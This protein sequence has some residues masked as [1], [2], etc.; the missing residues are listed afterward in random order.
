M[1]AHVTAD[2]RFERAS[3]ARASW[4]KPARR[5]AEIS[6]GRAPRA[7]RGAGCGPRQASGAG[8]SPAIDARSALA[9]DLEATGSV[10]AAS[11]GDDGIVDLGFHYH[12]EPPAI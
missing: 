8:A 4:S 2:R 10:A 3:E 6:S 5:M 9:A 12:A 1:D 11:E 7:I